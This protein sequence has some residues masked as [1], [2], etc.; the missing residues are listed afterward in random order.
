MPCNAASCVAADGDVVAGQLPLQA[1]RRSLVMCPACQ[2]T[3]T[4]S[5]TCSMLAVQLWHMQP[6]AHDGAARSAQF[7]GIDLSAHTLE[8]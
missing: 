3:Y 1:P 4:P 7:M 6:E 2:H 5:E 8:L